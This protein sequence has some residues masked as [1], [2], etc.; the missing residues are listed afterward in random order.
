MSW[1]SA[2][3]VSF[4]SWSAYPL[5]RRSVPHQPF[6]FAVVAKAYYALIDAA[7][8][9]LTDYPQLGMA[10]TDLSPLLRSY[11]VGEHRIYYRLTTDC[12]AVVRVLHKSMDEARNL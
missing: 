9:R 4:F 7:L 12:V 5:Q 3:E 2:L 6:R 1:R 8:T 10:R 11:P